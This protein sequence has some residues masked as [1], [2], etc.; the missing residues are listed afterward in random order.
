M[1][2]FI[3]ATNT[4]VGKTYACKLLIKELSQKGFKVGVYKPIE[5]GF[6]DEYKSDSFNILQE[7][8]KYNPKLKNLNT[9][10]ITPYKFK[11]PSSPIVA[12]KNQEIKI[13]KLIE[14][15]E[16][17]EKLCD[18]LLIEGA[19]GLYVPIEDDLFMIDLIKIFN[20]K[21]L[22][23]SSSKLGS[24]NESILSRKALESKNIDYHWCINLYE[25]KDSFYEISYPYYQKIKQEIFILDEDINKIDFM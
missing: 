9:D 15:K 8:K 3:T 1:N 2:I 13:S 7:A 19:G 6:K 20:S 18:I 23:I 16:R 24:I 11:L 25:D 17:L 10:D 14:V 5:T 4:N 21:V 12:K 22:L